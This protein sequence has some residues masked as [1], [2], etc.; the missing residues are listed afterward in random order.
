MPYCQN[1]SAWVS[2]AECDVFCKKCGS[3]CPPTVP[4]P[5]DQDA[6]SASIVRVA[7]TI[8]AAP[9]FLIGVG[10]LVVSSVM[11]S[12]GGELAAVP[13]I[14]CLLVGSGITL[15]RNTTLL[16]ISLIVG[17]IVLLLLSGGLHLLGA[18]IYSR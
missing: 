9:L 17:A 5:L 8:V 18:A 2:P 13:A 3:I 15:F 16:V 14:V 7:K 12:N 4:P 1:C 10:M 6:R 11:G